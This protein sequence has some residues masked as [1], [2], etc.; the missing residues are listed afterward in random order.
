MHS[1][2]TIMS[3]QRWWFWAVYINPVFWSING[4]VG[5]QLGNVQ[6]TMTL[7]DGGTT[8]VCPNTDISNTQ[9]SKHVHKARN[10][11]RNLTAR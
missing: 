4:L 10:L 5:T 11:L 3:M 6:E 2:F 8:Q 9:T 1:A 7:Q